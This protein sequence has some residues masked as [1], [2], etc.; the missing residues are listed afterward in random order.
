M[1]PAAGSGPA[2]I[3]LDVPVADGEPFRIVWA[4]DTLLGDAANGAIEEHGQSWPLNEVR[5]LLDGDLAIVNLEAPLTSLLVPYQPGKRYSYSMEPDLAGTLSGAGID[6]VGLANNHV[7]DRGPE[8]V[9]DTIAFAIMAGLIP[10]GAGDDLASA[11]RP[12]IIETG[13]VTV[14]VVFLAEDYGSASTADLDRAGTVALSPASIAR[15]HRTAAA[16]GADVVI[17]FVHWGENYEGIV[18]QQRRDAELF[19]AAGYNLVIGTGP[20]VPQQ[21]EMIGSMPVLYSLGN[22]VFGT[23]GRFDE[24]DLGYGLVVTTVLTTDGL[25]GLSV[26]CIVTDNRFVDFR[27]QLCAPEEAEALL[28]RLGFHDAGVLWAEASPG[29]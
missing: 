13:S 7:M 23:P 28:E 1:W 8:G 24:G 11:E 22:F 21:V 14:G 26:N 4:G 2:V 12:L 9:S 5:G 15:G 6:V 20:H 16:A 27:P 18:D 10:V 3:R 29:S 19:A 17:A 25:V